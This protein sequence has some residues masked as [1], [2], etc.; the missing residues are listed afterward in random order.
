MA[1]ERLRWVGAR[2]GGAEQRAQVPG[3]EVDVLDG[4]DEVLQLILRKRRE[5]RNRG[6][7]SDS[8]HNA[9]H[10]LPP[11]VPAAQAAQVAIT[12]R[13]YPRS[14]ESQ[15]VAVRSTRTW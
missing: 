11:S 9:P 6:Q 3:G 8:N 5:E 4:A 12:A 10:P 14:N 13:D 7:L 1:L 15:R 2:A